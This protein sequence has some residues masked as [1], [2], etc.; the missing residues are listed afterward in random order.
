MN[1]TAPP[2]AVLFNPCHDFPCDASP[3]SKLSKKSCG[4]WEQSPLLRILQY[5]D[6][7]VYLVIVRMTMDI[8]STPL[9]SSKHCI[10]SAI[11]GTE[12]RT[13]YQKQHRD[14]QVFSW[15]SISFLVALLKIC[16]LVFWD[17][18]YDINSGMQSF[19]RSYNPLFLS[20]FLYPLPRNQ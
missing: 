5:R 16:V 8:I 17:G 6:S 14:L 18:T 3:I 2:A 12:S 10:S 15:C 20:L 19:R 13:W 7:N 11:F 9:C 4:L 1:V